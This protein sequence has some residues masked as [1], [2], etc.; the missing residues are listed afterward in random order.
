MRQK[1]VICKIS[2]NSSNIFALRKSPKKLRKLIFDSI[3]QE[4]STIFNDQIMAYAM[5]IINTTKNYRNLIFGRIIKFRRDDEIQKWDEN[6]NDIIEKKEENN[7]IDKVYFIYEKNSEILI[8]EERASIKIKKT[9]QVISYIVNSDSPYEIT[10][11]INTKKHG[12]KVK[13]RINNLSLISKANF[14][15]IPENP[16][17]NRLFDKLENVSEELQSLSSQHIFENNQTGLNYG[18]K[19]NELIEDVNEAKGRRYII[20]GKKEN[21]E[22]DIIDSEDFTKEK[23]VNVDPTDE[24]REQ[25]IWEITKE[26]LDL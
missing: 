4:H 19:F 18:R 10:I 12:E 11:D 24:G 6:K 14:S 23:Y 26:I 13:R 16:G 17:N 25:G 22:I 2:L 7:V 20:E 21:G 15:L 1:L 8:I 3:N 5:Q 9:L